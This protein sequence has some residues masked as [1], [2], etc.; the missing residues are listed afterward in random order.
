M[1]LKQ[2]DELREEY[3]E[4]AYDILWH[5]G[6]RGELLEELISQDVEYRMETEA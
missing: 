3:Y 6:Y 5:E 1:S 4:Q 2:T